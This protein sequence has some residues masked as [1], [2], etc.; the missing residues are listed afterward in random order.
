MISYGARIFD[1]SSGRF[2]FTA[3]GVRSPH[4]VGQVVAGAFAVLIKR[5]GFSESELELRTFVDDEGGLR[6]M[7]VIEE[8]AMNTAFQEFISEAGH[9]ARVVRIDSGVSPA[10]SAYPSLH[11]L[12]ERP[13]QHADR[14]LRAD[15]RPPDGRAR[16][17]RRLG[18]LAVRA[19][20]DSAS[21]FAALL[22][23]EQHG[24][25]LVAPAGGGAR[26]TR[27]Y[28]PGTLILETEFE[29]ARARCG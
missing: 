28:R 8:E 3:P 19:P 23:D 6:S 13:G 24:R 21:C 10:S 15:R 17:A 7:D 26:G 1:R 5:D 9:E 4:R 2:I 11:R 18:R 22:G 12:P 25:W 14:G 27:R 29:T 16:R 20:F